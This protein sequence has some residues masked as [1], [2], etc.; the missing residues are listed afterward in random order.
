MKWT[1]KEIEILK[2]YYPTT[3][4][5]K[6]IE[7]FKK[8]GKDRTWISIFKK[9]NKFGLR[10]IT[11]K[12]TIDKILKEK[13]SNSSLEDVLKEVR[14]Y[15]PTINKK[16]L[17]MRANRLGLIRRGYV[18]QLRQKKI[19]IPQPSR[20]LAWFLGVLAGD[21]YVTPLKNEFKSYRALLIVTSEEFMKQFAAVGEMLFGI[22]PRIRK[23]NKYKLRGKWRKYYE[24]SFFSKKMVEFLGDWRENIW[25]RTFRKKFNWVVE[26]KN[27]I[28]A[29]L[30][31]FFDSEGSI[32]YNK[33]KYTRR[34]AF[35][36][37]NKKARIIIS[38]MLKKLGVNSKV[39]S[40]T[41]QIDGKRNVKRFA[42]LIKSCIPKKKRLLELVKRE[43]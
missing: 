6:L 30:S 38:R 3:P 25:F 19:K 39:Y 43:L 36:I 9:A 10:K 17:I 42:L 21:G 26:N 11:Y 22:K 27:Y 4:K 14:K 2:E 32:I 23:Y 20:K 7:I 15:I 28:A 31:G 37:L 40:H 12:E 5:N 16:A 35:S 13:Y 33:E 8:F 29:F 1:N 34:I 18:V 24:C 41:I